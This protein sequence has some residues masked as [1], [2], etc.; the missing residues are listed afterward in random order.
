VL[1]EAMAAGVPIV[2]TDIGPCAEVLAEGR[3][4][5]LVP[6]SDPG[7]LATALERLWLDPK[8]RQQLAEA[9]RA[10]AEGRYTVAVAARRLD[11]LI[12]H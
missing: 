2:A 6:P 1:A 8:L 4:G 11:E 9:G 10:T 3:A 5:L 12:Q 7:Q